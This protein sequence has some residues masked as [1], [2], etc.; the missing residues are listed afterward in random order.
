A[1]AVLVFWAA[2]GNL[3]DRFFASCLWSATAGTAVIYWL[4]HNWA[5]YGNPIEFLT[6][7]YS[8]QNYFLRFQEKLGWADFA[9]GHVGYAFLLAMSALA[10][11]AGIAFC[12]LFA[13]S[14]VK[15]LALGWKQWRGGGREAYLTGAVLLL[16]APFA[17]C[18]Y[19]L[20]KGTTQIYPVSALSLLNVRYG[21]SAILAPAVFSI[22]LLRAERSKRRLILIAVIV[23]AQY[24]WL[25]SDGVQQLA[26]LQE[27]YR[28]VHKTRE[29]RAYNKLE[30]Y[31]RSSPPPKKI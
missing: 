22:S 21:L 25:I 7:F 24:A 4:W 2:G 18:V 16:A 12:L 11:C 28:N 14:A 9:V 1:G 10:A 15:T 23:F 27:P 6:G 31:L 17:F 29:A 5:I 26:I 30:A 19:S 20:Y 8:A 3:K 13:V